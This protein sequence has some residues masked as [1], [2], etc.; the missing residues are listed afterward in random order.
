MTGLIIY[1]LATYGLSVLLS[2]Y[3]GPTDIFRN[4]RGKL[5]ALEC[6]VCTSVYVALALFVPIALGI[7]NSL[8]PLAVVGVVVL[9]ERLT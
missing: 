9:L 6:T 2:D 4:S 3:D 1:A 8:T 7:G 5:K